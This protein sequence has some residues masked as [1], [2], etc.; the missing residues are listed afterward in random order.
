MV[1]DRKADLQF[2]LLTAPTATWGT[3]RQKGFAKHRQ[4]ED[5]F[6][7]FIISAEFCKLLGALSRQL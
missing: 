1:A 3:S 5:L 2:L 4:C 7:Y 6:P